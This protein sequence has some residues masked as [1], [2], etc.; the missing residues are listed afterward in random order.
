VKIENAILFDFWKIH[1]LPLCPFPSNWSSVMIKPDGVP[2]L[3][4][5]HASLLVDVVLLA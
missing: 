5:F 1:F 3:I 4:A 2:F